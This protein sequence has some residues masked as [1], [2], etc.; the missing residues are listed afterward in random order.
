MKKV[1]LLSLFLVLLLGCNG[2]KIESDEG[3]EVNKSVDKISNTEVL[4]KVP[5]D[6]PVLT[7][8]DEE[9]N[10]ETPKLDI[11]G[12]MELIRKMQR[13]FTIE[14]ELIL[15]SFQDAEN[16]NYLYGDEEWIKEVNESFDR[17]SQSKKILEEWK[18]R[19]VI[20]VGYESLTDLTIESL[21]TI[22]DAG[23]V[24]NQEE[25]KQ[26]LSDNFFDLVMESINVMKLS[27]LEH[28]LK[29]SE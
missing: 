9:P 7:E 21:Q 17:L 29:T 16:E 15:Y 3:V 20:P 2:Q 6:I 13:Q 4:D 26:A 1:F 19:D 27:I 25:D 24:F 18:E 23:E 8:K 11:E 10:T 28:E 22:S 14:G 12:Y 5:E